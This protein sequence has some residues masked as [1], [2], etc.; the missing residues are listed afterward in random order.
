MRWDKPQLVAMANE[1]AAIVLGLPEP[2]MLEAKTVC[3][4]SAWVRVRVRVRG[5]G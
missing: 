3:G 1:F 5:Y 4:P 2:P